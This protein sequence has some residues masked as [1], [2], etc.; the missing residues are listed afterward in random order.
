MP[1]NHLDELHS[2]VDFIEKISATLG[3]QKLS[4][5][6]PAVAIVCFLIAFKSICK[7]FKLITEF[8]IK[9][10]QRQVERRRLQLGFENYAFGNA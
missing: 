1:S 4:W 3:K 9:R 8:Y 5:S 6:D 2:D 10:E 7:L